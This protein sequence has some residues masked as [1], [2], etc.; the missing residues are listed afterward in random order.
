MAASRL[1]YA[2]ARCGAGWRALKSRN[3]RRRN[4]L[5]GISAAR[6]ARNNVGDMADNAHQSRAQRINISR[7]KNGYARRRSIFRGDVMSANI[8]RNNA[9][10]ML[11]V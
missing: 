6:R 3:V 10:S 5:Y 2:R 7:L 9:A 8:G 4:G 11:F 1:R